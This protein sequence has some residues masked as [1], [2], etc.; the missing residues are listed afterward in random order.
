MN[1]S[2][3]DREIQRLAIR[4]MVTDGPEER[5]K[6][7]RSLLDAENERNLLRSLP[8]QNFLPTGYEVR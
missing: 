4:L 7:L 5:E 3:I 1:K 6:I 8:G 2:P